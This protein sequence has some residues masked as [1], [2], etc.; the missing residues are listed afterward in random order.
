MNR[1][2]KRPMFRIGGST[3]TGITSGLDRQNYQNGGGADARRFIQ[4]PMTPVAEKSKPAAGFLNP[5]GVGL[6]MGTLPG[7]LTQF[8]LNLASATPRGN[9][10]ATAAES[11][12]EPFSQFQAAKFAE[13]QEEREFKRDVELQMLK[14]LDE[15]SRSAIM[16]QAEEGYDAGLYS[17][18]NEGI[19]RLLQTK[20]FGVADRPGE[21]RQENIDNLVDIA[22]RQPGMDPIRDA[23]IV[24]NQI[25]VVQ[26]YKTLEEN[27]PEID[28]A[29]A[30][31]IIIE[32]RRKDYEPG[33]VYYSGEQD[34]FFVFNGPEADQPFTPVDVKR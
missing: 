33:K 10:F 32:E 25:T 16:K 22:L 9:I 15:D 20:E 2:L 28:F 3:G 7:F 19:R 12:K 1:I 6:G 4:R 13:A 18:V 34:Q 11:A 27:N 23:P 26:D 14:N 5:Q 24:K 21:K 17:S 29:A 8:G 31:L 30:P